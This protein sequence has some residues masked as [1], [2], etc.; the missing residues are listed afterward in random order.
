M[1][2]LEYAGQEIELLPYKTSF[3]SGKVI[4]NTVLIYSEFIYKAIR[5][6]IF[7]KGCKF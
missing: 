2:N 5:R 1:S 7:G 6:P 4:C 3:Y